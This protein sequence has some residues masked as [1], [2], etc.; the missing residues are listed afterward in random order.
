MQAECVGL[1]LNRHA[2]LECALL[3]IGRIGTRCFA[4]LGEQKTLKLLACHPLQLTLHPPFKFWNVRI[5]PQL[6]TY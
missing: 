1:W 6:L 2:C 5:L 3:L 4:V